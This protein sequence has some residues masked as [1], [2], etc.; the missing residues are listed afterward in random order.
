M[1]HRHY[2]YYYY[3][4]YHSTRKLKFVIISVLLNPIIWYKNTELKNKTKKTIREYLEYDRSRSGTE[5]YS[6]INLHTVRFCC[7]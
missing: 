4:Y 5:T 1:H 2:Y 3:Y 6:S 7:G